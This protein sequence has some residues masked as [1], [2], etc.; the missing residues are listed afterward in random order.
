MFA[1]SCSHSEDGL[2]GVVGVDLAG[3]LSTATVTCGS[4]W[5]RSAVCEYRNMRGIK[6]EYRHSLGM[7]GLCG[8]CRE[9][10]IS[11]GGESPCRRVQGC[12]LLGTGGGGVYGGWSW[13]F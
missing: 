8:R 12:L 9:A 2:C 11:C 3:D 1:L 10:W 7:R 5:C 13:R 6:T 4:Q